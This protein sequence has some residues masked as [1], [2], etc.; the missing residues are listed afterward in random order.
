MIGIGRIHN[1]D[2]PVLNSFLADGEHDFIVVLFVCPFL[3]L[4]ADKG[5]DAMDGLQ[6]CRLVARRCLDAAEHDAPAAAL[7]DDVGFGRLKPYR[8]AIQF[9]FL[10]HFGDNRHVCRYHRVTGIKYGMR[11]CPIL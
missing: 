6:L 3:R 7:V 11:K 1:D 5:R 2:N 9:Y 8:P 10:H 4:V